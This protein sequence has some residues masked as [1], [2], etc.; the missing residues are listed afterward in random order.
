MEFRFVER[1]RLTVIVTLAILIVAT[2]TAVNLLS[3]KR[4]YVDVNVNMVHDMINDSY[5]DQVILDV[6]PSIDFVYGHLNDAISIPY[7]ELESRSSELLDIGA[8]QIIVYCKTG[9]TSQKAC[10]LLGAIGFNGLFNMIGG[11]TEWVNAGYP[12]DSTSH[13][14]TVGPGSPHQIESYLLEMSGERSCIDVRNDGDNP[15]VESTVLEEDA[16]RNVVLHSFEI[17][18]EV[19]YLT[20]TNTLLWSYDEHTGDINRT[21]EF[22]EIDVGGIGLSF[23][24]YSFRYKVRHRNYLFILETSLEPL[25]LTVYNRSGTYAKFIPFDDPECKSL[26][27]V[28]F[29]TTIKLSALYQELASVAHSLGNIYETSTNEGHKGLAQ[30]YYTMEI[31]IQRASGFLSGPLRT[32]DQEILYSTAVVADDFWSCIA[33]QIPWSLICMVGCAAIA[34][35]FPPALPYLELCLLLGCQA[36]SSVICEIIGW[37]P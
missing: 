24:Y 21:V 28:N 7:N 6:R 27:F 4:A 30:N 35:Y 25:D 37:C 26:E 1:N 9:R 10:E 11:I 34:I 12:I 15:V 2:F 3:E 16:T 29:Q 8:R 13:Q 17:D 5:Q 19:F 32:Y 14:V 33:C 20:V 23:R 36:F 31:E 22:L 18:K